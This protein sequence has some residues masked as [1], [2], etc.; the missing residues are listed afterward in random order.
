MKRSIYQ[1]F[2]SGV[3]LALLLF[4]FVS[5]LPA[6]QISAITPTGATAGAQAGYSVAISSDANTAIIGAPFQ[7]SNA[8]G[9]WIHK[10]T[11]YAWDT[12]GTKLTLGTLGVGAGQ[13]GYSV[14]ISGD[15]STVVVG[16]PA[17]S[18]RGAGSGAVWFYFYSS[19]A[20]SQQGA[21]RIGNNAS[22][23]FG[24]S[25]A[26][27]TDGNTAIVGAPGAS[28]AKVFIRSS[29]SWSAQTVLT[30][31]TASLFGTSVAISGDGNTALVGAPGSGSNA[32]G[33]WIFYRTSG[34]WDSGTQLPLG[35]S[36][37]SQGR[38]GM[39]VSLSG[40][41]YRAA[42]GGY[43]ATN[44]AGG[45]WVFTKSGATW[46]QEVAL[47]ESGEAKG[48]GVALSGDGYSLMAGSWKFSSSAGLFRQYTRSSDPVTQ[49]VTWTHVNA[50]SGGTPNWYCGYSVAMPGNANTGLVA[51]PGPGLDP[52]VIFVVGVPDL[53]LSIVHNGS[54]VRG[55]ATS[56]TVKVTNRGAVDT[57]GAVTVS[58][59]IPA[60][61]TY[62]GYSGSGWSCSGST[63]VTCTNSSTVTPGNNFADLTLN[64]T[65]SSTAPVV[66]PNTVIVS[67]T[68]YNT[69]NNRGL[70]LIT[71]PQ[72]ADLSLGI[73]HTG[74]LSAGAPATYTIMVKNAG[75][76]ATS[77]TVT[78][79]N[80]LPGSLSGGSVTSASGWSGC[81][82]AGSSLSCTRSDVLAGG[83]SYPAITYTVTVSGSSPISN[84]ATV[85]NA[86]DT[87]AS[88]NS[89]TDTATPGASGPDLSMTMSHAGNFTHGQNNDW[90]VTVTNGGSG[91][92]TGAQVS[93]G[94]TVPVGATLVSMSGTGWTCASF[95]A[96]C[97]RSDVLTPGA[98]YPS[99]RVKVKAASAGNLTNN[100][101]VAGGGDVNSGNNS[102]SNAAVV[103]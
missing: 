36:A 58:D 103:N 3:V 39:R 76:A 68:E 63:T 37:V 99:I 79:S 81:S 25:V 91:P 18:T 88:N 50:V 70:D 56:Y 51:C 98:S 90:Y 44:F 7:S 28:T 16:G 41:G 86:G 45:V 1:K 11:N 66:I 27:S 78:V 33:V 43:N 14:A 31:G 23:L 8:G 94:D 101:T 34:V 85:S 52:G 19:G 100:A 15:G 17:D 61:L 4:G 2:G 22:D 13:Q 35:T 75:T 24:T 54:P 29:G 6:Q 83:G 67:G 96:T 60:G 47:T 5:A 10:R 53:V 71:L 84:S 97:A 55:S 57:S 20:F 12:T 69:L 80:I 32:G 73:S 72:L 93:V 89:A 59:V 9:A 87:V 95:L 62:T 40:D 48:S 46:T 74:A 82:F 26:L 77:G 49:A 38:Q 30:V 42:V 92:T 65:I 64:G 102:A 21:L